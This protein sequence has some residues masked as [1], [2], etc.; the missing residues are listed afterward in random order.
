MI[1]KAKA[2]SYLSSLSKCSGNSL[3]LSVKQEQCDAFNKHF[4]ATGNFF[5]QSVFSAVGWL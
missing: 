5:E 3:S 2:S 4:V 1:G